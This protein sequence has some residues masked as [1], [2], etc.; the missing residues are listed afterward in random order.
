M[1]DAEL[2]AEVLAGRGQAFEALVGRY[3]DACMRFARH[4][5]G[6]PADAEDAVQETFVRAYRGLRGYRERDSFRAWL[7]Q[8]LVNR[9]RTAGATRRRRDD[10]FVSGDGALAGA[11]VPDDARRVDVSLRLERALE[12]AAR[13]RGAGLRDDRPAHRRERPGAQDAREAR[14]RPRAREMGGFRRCMIPTM[15]IDSTTRS[16]R[17]IAARPPTRPRS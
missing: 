9:C 10:R 12:P 3:H 15:R 8:I 16:A 13:R 17:P 6:E 7:F 5:L 4:L 11:T 1:T 2:V 14:P